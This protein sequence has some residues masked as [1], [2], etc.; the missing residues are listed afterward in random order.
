VSEEITEIAD[1]NDNQTEM[2]SGLT[3]QV[4]QIDHELAEVMNTS[5]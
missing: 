1:E 3:R 4:E 5:V 2:V